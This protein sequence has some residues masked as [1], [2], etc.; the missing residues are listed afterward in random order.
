MTSR[1]R[2]FRLWFLSCIHC[3]IEAEVGY[4]LKVVIVP[5]IFMSSEQRDSGREI[6]V[7]GGTLMISPSP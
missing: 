6:G 7:F 3:D 2:Y 4:C 5:S 1:F